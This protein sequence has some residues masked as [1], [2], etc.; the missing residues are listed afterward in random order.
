M[1]GDIQI[2]VKLEKIDGKEALGYCNVLIGESKAQTSM[3]EFG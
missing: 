2:R 1:V 3:T